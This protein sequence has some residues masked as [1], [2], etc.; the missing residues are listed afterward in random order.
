MNR[1]RRVSFG[2]GSGAEDDNSGGNEDHNMDG[3]E[4]VDEGEDECVDVG[5]CIVGG[6]GADQ[7]SGDVSEQQ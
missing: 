5:D 3:D 7:R 2:C 1:K 4:D 6:G